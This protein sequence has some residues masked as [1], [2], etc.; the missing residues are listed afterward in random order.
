MNHEIVLKSENSR[1]TETSK[2][3]IDLISGEGDK[4]LLA[5]ET[6]LARLDSSIYTRTQDQ[7][8]WHSA[9]TKSCLFHIY[10][11]DEKYLKGKLWTLSTKFKI[12]PPF[13]SDLLIQGPKRIGKKTGLCMFLAVFLWSQKSAKVLILVPSQRDAHSLRKTILSMFPL[14]LPNEAMPNIIVQY[15]NYLCL[16]AADGTNA[17]LTI[18]SASLRFSRGLGSSDIMVLYKPEFFTDL[19]AVNEIIIPSLLRKSSIL[20]VVSAV[21]TCTTADVCLKFPEKGHILLEM[22]RRRQMYTHHPFHC[23][24]LSTGSTCVECT[25]CHL[26]SPRRDWKEQSEKVRTCF[27]ISENCQE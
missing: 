6:C 14:V 17:S 24:C 27:S 13:V 19:S 1:E 4:R 21:R 23:I 3:V 2:T 16:R 20:W 22:N 10:G 15:P 5:L 11:K 25:T 8:I 9:W 18:S 12:K 7:K 26:S